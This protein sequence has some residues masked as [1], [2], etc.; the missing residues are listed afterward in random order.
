MTMRRFCLALVFASAPALAGAVT[1]APSGVASCSNCHPKGNA[2]SVEKT[3][4]A[5]AARPLAG[6]DAADLVGAL[7]AFRSGARA[8]TVM[9]RIAKGFTDEELAAIAAWFA[10][11]R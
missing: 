6:R 11:Q 10:A 8:A 4:G 7:T 3:N 9:G 2:P 1:L 5:D